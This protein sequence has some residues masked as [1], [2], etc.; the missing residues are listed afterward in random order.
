MTSAMIPSFTE[1]QVQWSP[2]TTSTDFLLPFVEFNPGPSPHS[3]RIRGYQSSFPITRT[4]Y[5]RYWMITNGFYKN[6]PFL[7]FLGNLPETNTP[8][9]WENGNT[10]VAP[11]YIRVG[12]GGGGDFNRMIHHLSYILFYTRIHNNESKMYIELNLIKIIYSLL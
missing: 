8:F 5:L 3:Q 11:L 6:T 12:G 10:H 4:P 2:W 7:S 1:R 9:P